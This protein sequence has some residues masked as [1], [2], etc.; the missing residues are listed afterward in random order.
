VVPGAEVFLMR[1]K[2]AVVMGLVAVSMV[3]LCANM[4]FAQSSCE[5]P[6]DL[7]V[8][9][10]GVTWEFDMNTGR[11]SGEGTL[12]NVWENEVV[13]PGLSVGIFGV[14]GEL[15]NS[16][17]QRGSELRLAPGKSV[18]VKFHI[19]LKEAPATVMFTTFEGMAST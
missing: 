17:A 10:T 19:E 16:V 4:V 14:T 9:I 18:K 13:A 3:L 8:I 1:S 7:K 6:G 11:L 15:I 2:K 5:V 12:K